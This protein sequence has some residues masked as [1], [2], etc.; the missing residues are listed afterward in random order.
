MDSQIEI[1]RET[2]FYQGFIRLK[3]SVSNKAPSVITD[4]TLDFLFEDDLLRID[5]YEPPYEVRNG[6]ILLGN[7]SGG[8]SKSIAVYFDPLMCTRGAE[9][10]CQVTS[11]DAQGK[12]SSVFME[13]KLISVVCPIIKTELD[14]NVGRLKEFIEKLP[15]KDSKA[16]EI[17]HGFDVSKLSSIA[18]EVVEK[19]DVRHVRTLKTK[20]G[21][22]WE[23][24]YYGKTKVTKADIVI[25]VSISFEKQL[26]ELFAATESAEALT[27]LLAEVGR[28]LK[29]GI[30][31]RAS[32]KGNVINVTIKDSVIQRSNL[33]DLCSMDGTCPV[34]ILVE[35]SLI[36]HS[37]LISEKDEAR[38]ENERLRKEREEQEKLRRQREEETRLKK[39]EEE[40]LRREKEIEEQEKLRR[41]REEAARDVEEIKRKA[42]EEADKRKKEQERKQQEELRRKREEAEREKKEKEALE[43]RQREAQVRKRR[44]EEE[45]AR[46]EREEQEK[47]RK[48]REEEIKRREEDRKRRKF[49]EQESWRQA[50]ERRE[51]EELERKKREEVAKVPATKPITKPPAQQKVPPKKPGS[52]S[53]KGILVFSLIFGVLLIGSAVAFFGLNGD[54]GDSTPEIQPAPV[55][56]SSENTDEDAPAATVNSAQTSSSQNP[57]TYTNSVGMEFVLIPEGEFRMGSPSD[58]EGRYNGEDPVHKVTIEESYYLGKYEVTQEQWGEVMGS[59]PSYFE[60]D[61][62]PVEQVSWNDVQEFIEKLNEKEGTNKYRLPSEAE[63]EYACRAG[64]TTRYYF[65]DGDSKLG[66]YAWYTENS[67]S[68]THSVGQ[69]K[70]NPW[71][72][73]D[74]HGN[75]WE[76]CQDTYCSDYS[77]ALSDGSACE[78]RNPFA[79]IRRGGSGANCARNC[80]SAT[81]SY[82]GAGSRS[83]FL[84]F[85]VL[86]AV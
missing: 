78:S 63:W 60:G 64:T 32:G 43:R 69:K 10:N 84:G 70:P 25:K 22:D 67:G 30:E 76:W 53:G 34:N 38:E 81:R 86:R 8:T 5:R 61:D 18:R 4:V 23:I 56:T 57:D 66:D 79:R 49:E 13:P 39:A 28:D 51:G 24:W 50:D 31:F 83:S 68:K 71:G 80:R 6:K 3:M 62:L 58:E 19:H 42:Q 20:D 73:Y 27:G 41:Q 59:N 82:N 7:I 75:V 21:R 14:I 55:T 54:S 37:T 15:S 12:L 45:K 11:R 77:V 17:H 29:H 44:A 65:G 74:M 72:L 40:R 35:D 33:L 16:Y 48:Q 46:R 2:E 26:L 85:R 36:Q 52:S 1:K 47:L 9:I